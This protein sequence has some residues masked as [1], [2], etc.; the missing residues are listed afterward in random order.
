MELFRGYV[1]TK[2]KKCLIPFKDK[3]SS[4]LKSYDEVKDLDEYAG[5]LAEGTV[6]IDVDDAII[7]LG[8]DFTESPTI[9]KIQ[10]IELNLDDNGNFTLEPYQ[11]NN[12]SDNAVIVI[13]PDKTNQD[14]KVNLSPD[15][16]R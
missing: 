12:D 11:I 3:P 5:I 10:P 7:R 16:A 15:N 4:E 9:R 6:L 13:T 8:D 2:K 1:P 14:V